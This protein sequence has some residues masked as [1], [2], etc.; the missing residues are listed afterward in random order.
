MGAWK[1]PYWKWKNSNVWVCPNHVP[2]AYLPI[3]MTSC[4]YDR[5][6]GVRPYLPVVLDGGLVGQPYAEGLCSWEKCNTGINN[7]PS[8]RL[9]KRKY[10]SHECRKKRARHAYVVRK[11][12][13]KRRAKA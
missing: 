5:C 12:E 10:C 2:A 6:A 13:E 3:V 7:G 9:P 4:W 8:M 11:R 1:K